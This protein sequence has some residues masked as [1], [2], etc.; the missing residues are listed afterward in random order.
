MTETWTR[1]EIESPCV[2]ICMLHPETGLCVGCARTGDE[3]ARWSRM[4]AEE[5]RAVMAALPDREA[6]PASRRGGRA[7]TAG[8]REPGEAAPPVPSL[9]GRP[10]GKG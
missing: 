7:R 9:G 8:R 1:V 2:R 5:R 6:K 4:G 3:I 10:D